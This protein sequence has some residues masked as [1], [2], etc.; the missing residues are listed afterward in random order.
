MSIAR[1]FCGCVIYY[2]SR[3]GQTKKELMKMILWII[4][5]KKVK[6]GEKQIGS[7]ERVFLL[8]CMAI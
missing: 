7:K 5:K 3:L 4:T 8:K 2:N 6:D 1:S